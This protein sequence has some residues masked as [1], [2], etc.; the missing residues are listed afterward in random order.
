VGVDGSDTSLR[1]AA[2]AFGMARR[3]G[4]GLTVVFVAAPSALG[5]L[6]Y[7]CAAEEDEAFAAVVADMRAEARRAAHEDGVPV[8]LVTRRGDPFTELRATADDIKADFVFV[9]AS[10]SAGHR[11]VGSIATRL[12]K[13]GR[14]PVVVVP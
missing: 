9:G 7:S 11:F 6:G 2:S 4:S 5:S 1:A 14:W 13:L 3:Q 10:A 8:T 12:V